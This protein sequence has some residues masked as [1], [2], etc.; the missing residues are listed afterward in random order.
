MKKIIHQFTETG[1]VRRITDGE[2]Y[3]RMGDCKSWCSYEP[4]K[5]TFGVLSYERIEEEWKPKS[6]DNYF[7][8]TEMFKVYNDMFVIPTH[9][10]TNVHTERYRVGNCFQTKELAEEKLKQIKDILKGV[11]Q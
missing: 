8:I 11:T 10:Q 1:E 3:F 9:L 5:D 2:F 6:Q 4:S 7:Y